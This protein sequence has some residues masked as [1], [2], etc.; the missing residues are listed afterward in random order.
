MWLQAFTAQKELDLTWKPVQR[1]LTVLTQAT[2]LLLNANCVMVDITVLP[3]MAQL[4]LAHARKDIIVH[5]ETPLHSLSF[6]LEASIFNKHVPNI[7]CSIPS[8]NALR[9]NVR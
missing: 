8:E 5:K 9:F 2:G 7:V 1:E 4:S 6:K 3:E